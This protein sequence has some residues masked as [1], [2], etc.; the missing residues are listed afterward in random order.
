MATLVIIDMQEYFRAANTAATIEATLEL[1]NQ[2]MA[3]G[4]SIINLQYQMKYLTEDPKSQQ[5]EWIDY[6]SPGISQI[7]DA[8]A[9]YRFA[10]KVFKTKDSGAVEVHDACLQHNF[11]LSQL[12][13]CGVNA[14][15]CVF[16]TCKELAYAFG[17][18]RILPAIDAINSSNVPNYRELSWLKKPRGKTFPF[19]GT[20][21]PT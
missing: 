19:L 17:V 16:E 10:R 3:S 12:I 18:Q 20:R 1:C 15:A 9:D 13:V 6:T 7:E 11:D 21:V 14:E 5:R 8:I 4:H 2:M